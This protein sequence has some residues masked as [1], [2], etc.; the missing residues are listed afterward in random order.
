[1]TTKLPFIVE[2]NLL[3][4]WQKHKGLLEKNKKP[5]KFK[6]SGIL[7]NKVYKSFFSGPMRL[8]FLKLI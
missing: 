2:K 1:M 8:Y 4:S 3:F 5:L 6:L 7:V